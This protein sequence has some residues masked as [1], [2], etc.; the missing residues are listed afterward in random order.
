MNNRNGKDKAI[1]SHNVALAHGIRWFGQSPLW[2]ISLYL[3]N[4]LKQ[5]IHNKLI[6]IHDTDDKLWCLDKC[7]ENVFAFAA[8]QEVVTLTLLDKDHQMWSIL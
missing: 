5:I 2:D 6:M 1:K 3:H 7:Y 4:D 8:V